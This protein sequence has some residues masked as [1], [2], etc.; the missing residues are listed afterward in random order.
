VRSEPGEHVVAVL[1]DGLSDD[2]RRVGRD[3]PEDVHAHPLGRDEAVPGLGVERV[4]PPELPILPPE[5]PRQGSLELGL[6]RPAGLVG[7]GPEIAA[8]YEDDV[9]GPERSTIER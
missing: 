3:L 2:D 9:A 8:R 5:G 6:G 1:P 7:R 4:G